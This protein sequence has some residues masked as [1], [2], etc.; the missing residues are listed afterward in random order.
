MSELLVVE[1]RSRGKG[2]MDQQNTDKEAK[3]EGVL[4][5]KKVI[6]TLWKDF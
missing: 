1:R 4:P 6:I 2:D 3:E 5:P